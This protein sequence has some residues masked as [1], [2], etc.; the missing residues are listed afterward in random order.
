MR[1]H[2]LSSTQGHHSALCPLPSRLSICLIWPIIFITHKYCYFFYLWNFSFPSSFSFLTHSPFSYTPISLLPFIENASISSFFVLPISLF[3]FLINSLQS[4]FYSYYVTKSALVKTIS[5]FHMAKSNAH[6]SV[7]I[8]PDLPVA[9]IIGY[10]LLLD[11]LSALGFTVITLLA[12]FQPH[13][14]PP[15][16]YF[17]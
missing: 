2:T 16:S 6:I 10:F 13:W 9:F 4:G 12:F 8:S 1:F 17:G 15:L 5:D 7:L 11:A 14:L 3:C